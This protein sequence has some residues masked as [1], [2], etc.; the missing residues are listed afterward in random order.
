MTARN[1]IKV[2][3]SL[4]PDQAQ[5]FVEPNLSRNCLQMLSVEKTLIKDTLIYLGFICLKF[6]DFYQ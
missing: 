5:Y 6:P 3:N 2:S 1:I 4:D